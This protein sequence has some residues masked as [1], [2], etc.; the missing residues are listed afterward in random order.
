[1]EKNLVT[2]PVRRL[3]ALA[4]ALALALGAACGL[5][6][7]R[8]LAEEG[9]AA[10]A[11]AAEA[12]ADAAAV[13]DAGAAWSADAPPEV[14][15]PVALLVDRTTGT[16]LFER[17]ADTL[18]TPASLTKVMTALVT[19]ERASLSDVVT[20]E[21]ADLDNLTPESSVAGLKAGETLTV[22]DLLA[23]LLIPSGNDAAYVLARH[24]GGD[25]QTFVGLMNERA[26]SLGC[27][28]TH[29][30][31]PCG[32]SSDI[33]TTAR[34]LVT[35]FEAALEHPE[36]L[37]IAGSATWDLPA[38]EKNPART[39]ETTDFLI[40]SD[41]PVYMGETIVASK[42]GFTNDAGKCLLAAAERDGMSLVGIVMGASDE[43]DEDGVTPNFYDLRDLF[44]WGFGAWVT[45]NV[46]SEGDVLASRE[47]ALSQ[48]GDAV[49]AVA[50]GSIFGTV[51]R[52]TTVADLTVAVPW[53]GAE[54]LQAPVKEDT[55]LGRVAVSLNGRALGTVGRCYRQR[56]GALH[57]RLRHL[58]GDVRPG[59]HGHRG[60][61]HRRVLRARGYHRRA[62][63]PRPQ[64]GA[65]SS[66]DHRA[67]CARTRR[68]PCL[69]RR[70]RP[71][72]A[73][74]VAGRP[75]DPHTFH[76]PWQHLPLHDGAVRHGGARAAR[77]P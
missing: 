16:V 6:P 12:A 54:A 35:I 15:A 8:A 45:G 55:N 74:S 53:E 66:G 65:R 19:L 21:Q 62:C 77:R 57:T 43:T 63:L 58:V 41:S 51:P 52:G 64:E 48:D 9:A 59:A 75:H 3:S 39:L 24:V 28:S 13:A 42:T 14:S 60:G 31:D 68:E 30:A 44:E 11:S 20:V 40:E 61:R 47:V 2:P 70:S 69:R 33:V 72:Q 26:A 4:L 23:C 76:L 29:F 18:R 67:G 25:W 1:M 46:V 32:L 38:T 5:S 22:R 7:R 10:A 49:D 73:R 50:T 34:D 17:D 27:A 71:R 36:F 56:D 37:E